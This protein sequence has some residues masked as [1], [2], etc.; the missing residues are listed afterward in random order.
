MSRSHIKEDEDR[1]L[2]VRAGN[3]H[4]KRRVP[5]TVAHLDRRAPHVRSSLKTDDRREARRKRDLLEA[6]DDSYWASLILDGDN[7]PARRRYEAAVRRVEAMGFSF[8]DAAGLESPEA[9]ASLVERL[10]L[11]LEGKQPDIVAKSLLGAVDVPKTTVSDAFDIYCNEI[12]ADELV[13]KSKLQ[14]DQWKKVKLRAVNNFKKLVDDKPM[15]EIT[16][17]DAKKLYRHWLGRIA[18]KDGLPTASFSSGNRDIG[19]MR[20]LYEAYFKHMGQPKRENPFAGLN[21]STK[22]KKK[23]PPFPTD[24]I[25]DPILKGGTLKTLNSAAR[26]VVLI[27][28]ETGA[29]PSEICNLDADTIVLDH[30]VPHLVIE[31]REDPDDPREIKT[32]SSRRKVPLVGVALAAAKANANGFPRY[33]NRENDLSATLNKYF[34]ENKL[35]PTPKHKI[36][37]FRHSF[38]DRMKVG[39]IDNE[40]R[41][42][43][44]GH[45]IDRPDYGAGGTMEWR[46]DEL[47]KIALPFERQ[48]V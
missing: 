22:R 33:R 29:R 4:Y 9:F 20:V 37:S 39:G 24:W 19:N 26:G 3:F 25:K 48:I 27:M 23:R 11:V 30:P 6:A 2:I 17:D 16:I 15:D 34:R 7:D 36:Y 13:G 32:E 8:R 41:K 5:A 28:I 21:F 38:E 35:F 42:I 45:S 1:Y 46:R 10:R 40:L 12:V 44:M 14:R 43:L 31:P 18:P 47:M